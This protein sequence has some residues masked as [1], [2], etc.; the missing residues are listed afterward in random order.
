M[1]RR[2]LVCILFFASYATAQ[3]PYVTL[4]G[5]IQSANGLPAANDVISFTPTQSFFVAGTA[6]IAPITVQ[7][8]TSIDGSVVATPNPLN[9]PQVAA[10]YSGT[11]GSGNYFVQEAW[12]DASSN[13]TLVGPEI[14]IQL[15]A[16][17]EIQENPPA[18]GLPATVV[19]RKIYIGTTSGGETLQGTVVGSGTF[20]QSTPLSSGAA[21]PSVNSTVCQ[22]IANDAGWPT[23]TGYVVT[24]T[25]PAGQ[26]MPGYPSQWQLLG[27]GN[28]LNLSQGLP[29][30]NGIVTYPSPILATPY[31]HS[32]QS[33]SGP[34]NLSY[35]L[36]ASGGGKLYGGF[37][38]NPN[39]VDGT[40]YADQFSSPQAA[41]NALPSSGGTVLFPCPFSGVAPTT[42][43]SNVHLISEC[44]PSN[45]NIAGSFAVS[46]NP[47]STQV[48]LTW[49]SCPTLTNVSNLMVD[50]ITLITPGN[51]SLTL[52]SQTFSI[53][54]NSILA[55]CGG[56]S[57]PCLVMTT[58]GTTGGSA[59]CGPGCNTVFN[60]FNNFAIQ[61]NNVAGG[62]NYAIQLYG[63]GTTGAGS[64]V[65]NNY[66]D[67]LL[68]T[69][70]VLN[71]IDIEINTD[72]NHWHDVFLN[73][74]N[75]AGATCGVTVNAN[76]P[77]FDQD[78]DA[79]DFYPLTII[80]PQYTYFVCSGGSTGNSYEVE[81]A[82]NFLGTLINVLG[83]MV[84]TYTAHSI[85]Y[86]G[87]PGSFEATY[88][89]THPHAYS[90]IT[91]CNSSNAGAQSV[92]SDATTNTWG[93][94]VSVGGGGDQV[95][96]WCNGT[97]WTVIGK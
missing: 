61:C 59:T 19:G 50:G 40:V 80:S 92:V 86:L 84:P 87:W 14:Q 11:L 45:A 29:L 34:L 69:G 64:A 63:S 46:P 4:T 71:G 66:F 13:V 83:T 58:T 28:T 53:F 97:N 57:I 6:I 77:N 67:G 78:A 27:P 55:G 90:K 24:L 76:A 85:G 39:F 51:C 43:L 88:F 54:E 5:K 36:T 30:Y 31:N 35:S 68:I 25:T 82:A 23:E 22:V 15:T 48:T 9:P 12:Y 96:V 73:T 89:Q 33:I 41:V 8:A 10:V 65:T 60:H 32:P 21:E 2:I 17:G 70:K 93:A 74:D 26:T 49:A 16:T 18:S 7:C 47:I 1:T 95:F 91:P 56:T 44:A 81:V 3:A 62:C 94:T 37:T 72:S 20:T 79:N 52:V 75:G 38:V 42:N